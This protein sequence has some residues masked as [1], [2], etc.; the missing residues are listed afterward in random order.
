MRIYLDEGPFA[1]FDE[2]KLVFLQKGLELG[3]WKD[4]RKLSL[5][6]PIS[7]VP[8]PQPQFNT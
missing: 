4:N 6:I 2:N 1:T 5:E 8:F 3:D 7:E